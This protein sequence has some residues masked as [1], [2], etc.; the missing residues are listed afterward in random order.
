MS[1]IERIPS[2]AYRRLG[3]HG[4]WATDRACI[5]HEDCPPP[6]E[7]VRGL[8]PPGLPST[9]WTWERRS[10]VV[11]PAKALAMLESVRPILPDHVVLMFAPRF[12]RVLRAG[13]A[14]PVILGDEPFSVAAAVWQGGRI[15]AL[16]MPC[17]MPWAP[18]MDPGQKRIDIRGRPIR[19][20]LK[21]P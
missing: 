12:A 3:K 17:L 13:S 9:R 5:L 8:M 20:E 7:P 2:A 1:R 21:A 16:V 15:I 10:G 6:I 4:R 19:F 11:T 18:G 14:C